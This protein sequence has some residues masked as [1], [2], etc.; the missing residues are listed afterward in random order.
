MKPKFSI[1]IP[2]F[3]YEHYID[4][5]LSSVHH[6]LYDNFEVFVSDNA[7]TDKS[8]EVIK[9]HAIAD[10]RVSYRANPSNIGFAGNL[11]E[12]GRMAQGDWMIMLSS[13]DVMNNNALAEYNKFIQLI[14]KE[15]TFAHLK[16]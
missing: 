16:K 2:N 6:Q 9:K 12:A 11:D 1:C 5:T 4:I 10:S 7:S 3:N 13:D 15:Q 14:P 8:I